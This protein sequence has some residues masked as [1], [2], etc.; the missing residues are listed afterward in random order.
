MTLERAQN[1]LRG[2]LVQVPLFL[3][4]SPTDRSQGLHLAASGG[5]TSPCLLSIF[6]TGRRW[7][8]ARAARLA[9]SG[10][11]NGGQSAALFLL[12]LSCLGGGHIQFVRQGT[13]RRRIRA[14]AKLL[15][16]LYSQS[17]SFI[18]CYGCVYNILHGTYSHNREYIIM[19]IKDVF[20]L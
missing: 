5:K 15:K 3:F 8:P 7:S 18:L 1:I 17:F 2:E 14:H 11:E 13:H 4:L 16:E 19:D 6:L 10:G 9:G 12:H 20:T